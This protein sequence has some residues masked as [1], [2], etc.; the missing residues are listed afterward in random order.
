MPDMV[1]I[2]PTTYEEIYGM[3]LSKIKSY[4]FTRMSEEDIYAI[5]SDY[6]KPS[7]SK[8]K[9]CKQNLSDR[10]DEIEQF[11][12]QLTDEEIEILSNLMVIEFI[13]SNY[14]RV[15]A[16]M[17]ISLTSKDFYALGQKD[18]LNAMIAMRDVYKKENSQLISAYSYKN[19][20]LFNASSEESITI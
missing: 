4:E 12:V 9:A 20:K 16:L 2:T 1:E 7:I 3:V 5:L 14:I 6:L 11:N 13:D 10:S 18:H 8:F 15:P 19:S 17:K